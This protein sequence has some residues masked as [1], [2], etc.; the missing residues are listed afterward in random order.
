MAYGRRGENL[1]R[2]I[3]DWS[4]SGT[5]HH[6]QGTRATSGPV[7]PARQPDSRK[8]QA[9]RRRDG[10]RP[11]TPG[12][13]GK[14]V[15]K[16]AYCVATQRRQS[17]NVN[18]GAVSFDF[19]SRPHREG[20]SGRDVVVEFEQLHESISDIGSRRLRFDF[21]VGRSRGRPTGR[22]RRSAIVTASSRRR[23]GRDL[24]A[25]SRR[26]LL[27]DHLGGQPPGCRSVSSRTPRRSWGGRR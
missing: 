27:A 10:G 11:M 14:S 20:R 25:S 5:G 17:T 19:P 1:L 22:S 15:V 6:R 4:R 24:G 9:R 8:I 3:G 23:R 26:D 21:P 7:G 12:C 16:A 18:L 13:H 2:S